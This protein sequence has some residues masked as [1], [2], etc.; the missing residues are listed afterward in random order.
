M[1]PLAAAELADWSLL[2]FVDLKPVPMEPMEPVEPVEPADVV[3]LAVTH[4][5]L[6]GQCAD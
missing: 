4:H 5:P 3:K 2:L 1:A 6:A